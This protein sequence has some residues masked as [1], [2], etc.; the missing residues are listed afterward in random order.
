M[1]AYAPT[2]SMGRKFVKMDATGEDNDYVVEVETRTN[3][4]YPNLKP[5]CFGNGVRDA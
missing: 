5:I 2:A 3:G 1:A 4:D